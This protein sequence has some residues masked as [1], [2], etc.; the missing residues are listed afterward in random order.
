MSEHEQRIAELF[1]LI[2]S[3]KDRT[4]KHHVE[5]KDSSAWTCAITLKSWAEELERLLRK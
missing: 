2:Q 5:K 1:I 3:A 4:W